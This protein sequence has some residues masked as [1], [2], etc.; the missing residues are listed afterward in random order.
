MHVHMPDGL[1]GRLANVYSYVQPIYE[2]VIFHGPTINANPAHRPIGASNET[3]A[4][5]AT[6]AFGAIRV[7]G[8]ISL[9][10]PSPGAEAGSNE[11]ERKGKR[12]IMKASLA[13][14][15]RK[16]QLLEDRIAEAMLHSSVDDLEIGDL[17]RQKLRLKEEIERI[18]RETEVKGR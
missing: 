1:S 14:L 15:E 16:H 5:P 7:D 9:S 18:R 17:K 11:R 13:D 3:Q 8:S 6:S 10:G 2:R 12:A 4:V